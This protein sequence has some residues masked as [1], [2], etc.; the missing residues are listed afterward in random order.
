RFGEV[1][2]NGSQ[3]GEKKIPEAVTFQAGAFVESMLKKLREQSFVLT[4][5]DDAVANVARG[6]HVEFLA[7][8]STGAAVVAYGND[9][10]EVTDDRCVGA[11]GSH[12]GGSEDKALETLEQRR[13]SGAAADGDHAEATLARRFLQGQKL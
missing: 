12:L 2:S 1:V 5:G 11:C 7:Q 10:T 13:Q 8:P 6:E 9:G 3:R 4:K